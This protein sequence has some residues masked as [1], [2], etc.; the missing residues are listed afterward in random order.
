MT[1]RFAVILGAFAAALVL[2]FAGLWID[3]HTTQTVPCERYSAIP[4]S[5][6]DECYNGNTEIRGAS[7]TT[8]DPSLGR[9]RAEYLWL[10]AAGVVVIT[11]A[12]TLL[13]R[14]PH[15]A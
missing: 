4:A 3:Q 9:Q 11:L 8:N 12:G 7:F 10:A 6:V 15:P 14:E 2:C 5:V 13:T 1:T